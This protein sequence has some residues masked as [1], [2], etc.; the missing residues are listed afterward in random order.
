MDGCQDALEKIAR[1]RDLGQLEDDR[2]GVAH[3]AGADLDEPGLQARQRP[4][5]DLV[6]KLGGMQE[7][8]D[9]LALQGAEVMLST[10]EELATR[11][12][13]DLAKWGKIVRASGIKAD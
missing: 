13:G 8:K 6:G 7:V 9:R 1:D 10:P 5:R 11:V 4:R 3:D 12:R 2:T